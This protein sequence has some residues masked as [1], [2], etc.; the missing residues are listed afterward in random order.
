[1]KEYKGVM[2][3]LVWLFWREKKKEKSS[4]YYF[5]ESWCKWCHHQRPETSPGPH[6]NG[7]GSLMGAR[8]LSS[9]PWCW[10]GRS[11]P[12]VGQHHHK[13]PA[14]LRI[15][16]VAW[17]NVRSCPR[18]ALGQL[19]RWQ[20]AL[21]S[22]SSLEGCE[23]PFATNNLRSSAFVAILKWFRQPGLRR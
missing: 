13:Q 22:E 7:T 9:P 4:S 5:L 20:T 6:G 15:P 14:A 23:V 3:T 8:A 2:D 10:G 18:A 21:L 17:W 12:E 16:S 11:I 1:M 19:Q